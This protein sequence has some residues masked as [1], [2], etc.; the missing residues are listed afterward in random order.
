MKIIINKKL[1]QLISNLLNFCLYVSKDVTLIIRIRCKLTL[2]IILFMSMK[3]NLR[4]TCE[5]IRHNANETA[6]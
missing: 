2:S 4:E 3:L 5:D 1:L 6:V